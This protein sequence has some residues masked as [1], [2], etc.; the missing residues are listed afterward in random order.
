MVVRVVV[1]AVVAVTF[2]GVD[3]LVTIVTR[4]EDL[5]VD[6][7]VTVTVVVVVAVVPVT[8]HCNICSITTIIPV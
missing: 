6:G 4:D 8:T 7:V 2:V 1:L 3:L 5:G